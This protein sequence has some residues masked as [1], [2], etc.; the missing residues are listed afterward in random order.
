MRFCHDRSDF[1]ERCRNFSDF[2]VSVAEKNGVVVAVGS[3]GYKDVWVAGQRCRVGYFLDRMVHPDFRRQGIGLALLRYQLQLSA[4]VSLHYALVLADNWP[5]RRLLERAGFRAL[6]AAIRYLLLM[7]ENWRWT[8]GRLSC[9]LR[10]PIAADHA[11]LLDSYLRSRYALLD[12]SRFCGTASVVVGDPDRSAAGIVH[13]LGVK[14]VVRAPW[15]ARW[16]AWLKW[17]MPLVGSSLRLW[18]LG[19]VWYADHRALADLIQEV[20]HLAAEAGVDGILMPV[21]ANDP[22]LAD[23]R[24]FSLSGWGLP[25]PRVLMYVRG[26]E[27]ERLLKST[28]PVLP[29]PRDG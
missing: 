11:A 7:P 21:A 27:A 13:R 24:R 3:L 10:E 6:P 28:L 14:R 12:D 5:N 29:S 19:H 15:Y 9:Q 18:L 17:R 22:R 26:P 16:M 25:Q 4:P 1:W 2:Q 8:S 23:L 20:K